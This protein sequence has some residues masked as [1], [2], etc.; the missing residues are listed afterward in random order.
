LQIQAVRPER[1]ALPV[2]FV[3]AWLDEES[4][5]ADWKKRNQEARGNARSSLAVRGASK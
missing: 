4:Q 3:L 1:A 5:T 2:T